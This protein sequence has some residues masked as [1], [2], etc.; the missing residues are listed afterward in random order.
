M[1]G[2]YVRCARGTTPYDIFCDRIYILKRAKR[3]QYT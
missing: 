1:G 2:W 3:A